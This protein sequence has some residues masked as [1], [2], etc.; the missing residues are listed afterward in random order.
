MR[1]HQKRLMPGDLFAAVADELAARR[2]ALTKRESMALRL[3][4]VA[5]LRQKR[6]EADSKHA[7]DLAAERATFTAAMA[8]RS[9]P[10]ITEETGA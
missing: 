4:T 5:M 6:Q 8:R 1:G 10:D 9:T 3:E 7:R 2:Q